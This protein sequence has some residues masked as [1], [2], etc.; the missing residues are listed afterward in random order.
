MATTPYRQPTA[1]GML[2]TPIGSVRFFGT[3]VAGIDNIAP[4]Q[5]TPLRTPGTYSITAIP[6]NQPGALGTPGSGFSSNLVLVNQTLTPTPTPS[7]TAPFCPAGFTGDVQALSGTTTPCPTNTPTPLTNCNL[8]RTISLITSLQYSSLASTFTQELSDMLLVT[9]E[10]IIPLIAPTINAQLAFPGSPT[11]GLFNWGVDVVVTQRI[12]FPQTVD[13]SPGSQIWYFVSPVGFPVG[14][15]IPVRYGGV[16]YVAATD[17]CLNIQAV[18]TPTTLTFPYDRRAAANY[19]IEHSYDTAV[20]HGFLQNTEQRVTQPLFALSPSL[21]LPYAYFRYTSL[22]TINPITNEKITGSALFISESQW[23][24][25]MPMTSG[26]STLCNSGWR[27]C[28]DNPANNIGSFTIPFSTH[29][30]LHNY[31]TGVSGILTTPST[32]R[33]FTTTSQQ[34]PS[35]IVG[36]ATNPSNDPNGVTTRGTDLNIG[37]SSSLITLREGSVSDR[38]GLSTR[39]L[40]LLNQSQNGSLRTGDYITM[41][42]TGFS[43]DP[44]PNVPFHGLMVIG[45]QEAL[46]CKDAIFQNADFLSPFRIW[47]VDQFAMSYVL[48]NTIASNGTVITNPVPWVVDFTAPPVF[49]NNNTETQNPVPRPFYCTMYWDFQQGITNSDPSN[50]DDRFF[51]HDWQFFSLPDQVTVTLQTGTLNQLYVDP[52]WGW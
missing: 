34:F 1:T 15:W 6:Y 13:G 41:L 25:G 19:A 7:P 17:P 5:S 42:N 26:N 4:Y 39:V 30:D 45:W 11:R 46:D 32:G 44:P 22:G 43:T 18:S 20:N 50:G 23:M 40:S 3:A 2:G 28:Y 24:G 47:T 8:N 38:S 16:D 51:A 37:S 14:G 9:D 12:S 49:N 35:V 36:R 10:G 27:Y 52:E 31:W 29:G 48:G 33:V 21:T